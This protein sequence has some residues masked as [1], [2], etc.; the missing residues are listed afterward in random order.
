MPRFPLVFWRV[1]SRLNSRL[2]SG[3]GPKNRASKR[4][5]VI[6]TIGRKS[7]QLRSTPLQFEEVDGVYYVASARGPHADWYR[8]IIANP[9]VEVR[10]NDQNFQTSAELISEPWK[11]ADF[12]DLRLKKHPLFMGILLRLEGLPRKYSRTDLEEFAKRLAIVALPQNS[13]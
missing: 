3:Y 9:Q 6:T 10:V 12:L 1:L 5:L 4:V 7:S 11:I 2:V 13:S 8:N